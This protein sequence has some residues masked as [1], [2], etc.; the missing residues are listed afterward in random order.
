MLGAQTLGGGYFLYEFPGYVSFGGG[1]GSTVLGIIRYEGS[2]SGQYDAVKP[3]FNL[4][5]DIRAC[6]PAVR[7]ICAAIGVERLARA[8]QR[9]RRAAAAS[10]SGP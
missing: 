9:R 2:L 1:A 6:L 3:A 5:G 10:S 4:H 7:N 8:E